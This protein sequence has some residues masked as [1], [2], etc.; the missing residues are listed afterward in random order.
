MP[1]QEVAEARNAAARTGQN[2][3]SSFYLGKGVITTL[4]TSTSEVWRLCWGWGWKCVCVGGVCVVRGEQTNSAKMGVYRKGPSN[5][6][7]P[8]KMCHFL[9]SGLNHKPCL[10]LPNM[11]HHRPPMHAALLSPATSTTHCRCLGELYLYK[12]LSSSL[13]VLSLPVNLTLLAA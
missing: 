8:A 1:P 10:A 12:T 7:T 9:C 3:G 2:M 5:D 6:L 13:T 11:N 4:A